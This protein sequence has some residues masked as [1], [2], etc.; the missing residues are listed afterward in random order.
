MNRRSAARTVVGAATSVTS[1]ADGLAHDVEDAEVLIGRPRGRYVAV[2]GA[3]VHPAA[4]TAPAGR[5]CRSCAG[6]RVP[7]RTEESMQQ[8]ARAARRAQS[9][10]LATC[11][12]IMR[13]TLH[14]PAVV[15]S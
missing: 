1:A 14:R 10:W 13:G 8:L 11:S 15:W 2:C 9:R 12:A 4:L 5:V 6:L 3:I 7:D